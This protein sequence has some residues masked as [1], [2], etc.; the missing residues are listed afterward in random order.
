MKLNSISGVWAKPVLVSWSQAVALGVAVMALGMWC[1]VGQ[2]Q[3]RRLAP[4]V[5]TTI[6][7][8]PQEH[9]M[10]DG[11]RPLTEIP[12]T[13][14][15]LDYK[16]HLRPKSATVFEQAKASTLRRTIW[17]LE[18]SFKPM[19]LVEA[20]IPQANGKLQRKLIWYM[21]YRVRNLGGHWKAI[22]KEE[23]FR[24][25]KHIT[26]S[27]ELVNEISVFGKETQDL[28]FFPHFILESVE[29]NKEYLDRVIPAALAPIKAREFPGDPNAKL[30]DS[31]AITEV[32]IPVSTPEADKSVWGVVTW[33]D[34]DPRIDY[35]SVFVQGLTNA[36]R[37]E[38]PPGAFKSGDKPGTGRR[39][40]HK[41]LR[42]NFW[43]P[44]D[45]VNETE[46][47]IRYG[48][49]I[50][51]DAAEQARIFKLFGTTERLDYEWVYR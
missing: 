39:L 46:E 42:L 14:P 25:N 34:V 18:F 16:P 23:D 26:Y 17:N 13:I 38:D 30:F 32:P 48:M 1:A 10:Y 44:G 50:D 4:G 29:F 49:R 9:E 7:P 22:P 2:A 5:M 41:T 51:S 28:R 6:T 12:V 20:E 15:G 11:P 47:E 31:Q 40:M 43:R 27:K 45:A 37:Y 33:E 24:G 8:A 3:S 19:R 35:F 36:Y 21:V